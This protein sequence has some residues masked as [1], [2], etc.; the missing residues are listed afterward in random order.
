VRLNHHRVGEGA[1]LVLVH[2]LGAGWRMW[3]PVLDR[4]AARREVIAIDL[5]GFGASLPGPSVPPT[6][7]RLA[8]LVAAFAA[9]VGHERFHVAGNALGGGIALELGRAGRALSVC[10]LSPVGFA[11][12]R[13]RAVAGASLRATRALARLLAPVARTALG[14]PGRRTAV[15][16]QLTGRPW[17]VPPAAGAD[18]LRGLAGAP[19]F[20]GGLRAGASYRAAGPPPACPTTIAWGERDRLAPYRRQSARARGLLPQ[21]RHLTLPGCGHVPTWDDPERIA[22]VLLEAGAA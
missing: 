22:G 1:P 10:A 16:G 6:V 8:E 17:R 4:L 20:E 5:P 15:L 14:G 11:T 13:E 3:E 12:R 19:G 7:G 18:A 9:G 21:A 2:G